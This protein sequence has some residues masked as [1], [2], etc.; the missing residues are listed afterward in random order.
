MPTSW[1]GGVIGVVINWDCDLDLPASKCNPKYSFRRLDPK[2]IP[3]SSGYNFRL[4]A[5]GGQGPRWPCCSSS[6]TTGPGAGGVLQ[7]LISGDEWAPTTCSSGSFFSRFAKYYKTN[8]STTRTL[9][10]AYGIRIDVIV[11]G[12]VKQPGFQQA[13]N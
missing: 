9:I 4:T 12:Q 10:K 5:L 1:Q 8:G 11:H 2:H 7:L 6:N 3:A 13:Q